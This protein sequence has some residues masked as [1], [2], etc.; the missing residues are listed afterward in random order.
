MCAFQFKKFSI[1]DTNAQMKIGTDSVLL[2]SL[3][4]LSCN[5]NSVLDI[6]SGS[7][8][9]SLM[10]AQRSSHP[11]HIHSL[12][13]DSGA[14]QDSLSNFKNSPWKDC[15]VAYNEDLNSWESPC[16]FDLII[17]NPPYF[18]E[19]TISQVQQRAMA[20]STI[21]LSKESILDFVSSN[22]DSMGTFQ[23]IY[24]Y[25]SFP[26]FVFEAG[27]R[28]LFLYEKICIR[29]SVKKDY[30]RIIMKF[31]FTPPKRVEVRNVIIRNN[32]GEYSDSFKAITKDFYLFA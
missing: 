32:L 12:E 22:L 21:S 25:Q 13:K 15:F 8:I 17:S 6:G 9:L 18:S 11:V 3:V 7:G 29:D 1:C 14:F 23:L 24:P 27:K 26:D 5:P 31:K 30:K 10:V 19:D 2:G 16:V 4:D 28:D 20:R